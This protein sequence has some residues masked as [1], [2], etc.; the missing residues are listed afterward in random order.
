MN[1]KYTQKHIHTQLTAKEEEEKSGK[2]G[3]R[4]IDEQSKE[5]VGKGINGVILWLVDSLGMSIK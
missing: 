3:L 4:R 1:G 2:F 5:C